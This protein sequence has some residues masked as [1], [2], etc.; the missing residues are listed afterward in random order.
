[1]QLAPVL[2]VVIGCLLCVPS[3]VFRCLL[4]LVH[5]SEVGPEAVLGYQLLCS[6]ILTLGSHFQGNFFQ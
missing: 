2:G 4:F 1:M 3:G 5:R 6:N